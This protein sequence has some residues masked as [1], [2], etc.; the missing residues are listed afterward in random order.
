MQ[1]LYAPWRSSYAKSTDKSKQETTTSQECIFCKFINEKQDDKN[2]ILKRYHHCFVIL[3]TYPYNAGH[4]MVIP[5]A[6]A[7]DLKT[8]DAPTRQEIAEVM[9]FCTTL[10][11]QILHAQGMNI[12]LNLGRIG[13]AGIPTHLHWHILPRWQGDTNFLPLLANTTVISFN[14][15]EIFDLLKPAFNNQ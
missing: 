14:L 10:L 12:G 6:H 7:K 15:Q 9:S 13:G 2:F 1:D 4:L 8:L 11:E 3:N 5:F